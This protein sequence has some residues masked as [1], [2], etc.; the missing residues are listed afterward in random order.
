MTD[1]PFWTHDTMLFDGTFHYYHDKKHQVRG[2]A[3]VTGESYDFNNFGHSLERDV[4]KT[5][6]G[7]RIYTLMKPY[8][9]Q[10]DMTMSVALYGSPK[11]YADA[12]EAI[13]HVI[14]TNFD[15]VRAVEIGN[16]QAW[17]YAEDSVIVLWECF[18]DSYVRDAP[19]GKDENMALL[20]SAFEQWLIKRYPEAKQVVTPWSDPMWPTEEYQAFLR[21]RGYRKAAPGLFAKHL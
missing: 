8:V 5:A 7:K 1:D 15:G 12:D 14:K 13:G 2:R 17:Y 20:W 21:A 11:H 3:H 9:L 4:L 16:A 18:L 10:P 19:L 6:K